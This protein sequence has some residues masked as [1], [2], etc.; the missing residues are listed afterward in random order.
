MW[1]AVCSSPGPAKPDEGQRQHPGPGPCFAATSSVPPYE[2]DMQKVFI[3]TGHQ[4]VIKA[5]VLIKAGLRST[6]LPAR[7]PLCKNKASCCSWQRSAARH[8]WPCQ[9]P[10]PPSA[11]C[12]RA[13]GLKT[14]P[15]LGKEIQPRRQQLGAQRAAEKA[16]LPISQNA[17][18]RLQ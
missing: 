9:P 6:A 8:L 3:G 17:I 5:C 12:N 13:H 14:A 10:P 11:A 7:S 4:A 16:F 2:T 18:C 1:S 15:A